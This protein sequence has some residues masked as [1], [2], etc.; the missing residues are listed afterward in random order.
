MNINVSVRIFAFLVLVVSLVFVNSI[1]QA[2]K[3]YMP[4]VI[5]N[6]ISG[7]DGSQSGYQKL[8]YSDDFLIDE[9][10]LS[11]GELFAIDSLGFLTQNVNNLKK[12]AYLPYA[13]LFEEEEGFSFYKFRFIAWQKY[14]GYTI[15]Y[16]KYFREIV[17]D[18][19]WSFLAL[20]MVFWIMYF[21]LKASRKVTR[22]SAQ[23]EIIDERIENRVE[24]RILSTV[25]DHLPDGVI[26][27]TEEGKIY[28]A[29]KTFCDI[30]GYKKRSD[31]E[32]M[33]MEIFLPQPKQEEH[34][35]NYQNHI[36]NGDPIKNRIVE[37]V[38]KNGEKLKVM[39]AVSASNKVFGKS[40]PIATIKKYEN[41]SSTEK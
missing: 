12:G 34:K 14:N 25:F 35:I 6:K 36:R 33:P 20:W 29:N 28:K 41:D 23:N 15:I 16:R 38:T 26:I 1:Y 37:A 21:S 39:L 2:R 13:S 8:V 30:M 11:T 24:K 19:I 18:E 32:G 3:T 31:I 9:G 17:Q 22:E 5:K 4:F 7:L 27:G 40:Y 10:N